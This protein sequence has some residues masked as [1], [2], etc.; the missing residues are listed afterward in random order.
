[1]IISHPKEIVKTASI[2][3]ILSVIA[4]IL[5]SAGYLAISTLFGY[6]FAGLFRMF[7]YHEEHPLQYIGI[8]AVVFGILGA[9]WW[10]NFGDAIGLKR[11]ISILA[12][13]ALTI[14]IASVPGGI[15]WAIHDMQA[16]FFPEGSRF[17]SDLRWGAKEG[18]LVGWLVILMSIPYN[19]IGLAAGTALLHK[20]PELVKWIES[21]TK[22]TGSRHPIST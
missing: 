7:M 18:L 4:F 2:G 13:V 21:R 14:L 1:M 15:L 22:R 5:G 17:W 12:C 16:G 8:V 6:A 10:R 19:L 11:W 3:I 9:I 20:L